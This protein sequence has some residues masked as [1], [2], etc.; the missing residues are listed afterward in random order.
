MLFLQE[1]FHLDLVFN[2]I[3]DCVNMK[4]QSVLCTML[5]LKLC[6][7]AHAE[8]DVI[9]TSHHLFIVTITIIYLW[10]VNVVNIRVWIVET[11]FMMGGCLL[12]LSHYWSTDSRHDNNTQ[13][14]SWRNLS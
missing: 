9:F 2:H 1:L 4:H 10:L 6:H 8:I 3:D 11:F 12:R 13:S 14:K 5:S 7:T